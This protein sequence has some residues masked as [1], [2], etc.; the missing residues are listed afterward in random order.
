M[1]IH[2]HR[3]QQWPFYLC[4]SK[5]PPKVFYLVVQYSPER[6]AFSETSSVIRRKWTGN[7]ELDAG[8]ALSKLYDQLNCGIR[9]LISKKVRSID[10]VPEW[11]NRN[12]FGPDSKH[13]LEAINMK[14]VV[15]IKPM[16]Y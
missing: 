12:K 2:I 5:I 9:W 3:D 7:Y 1:I 6:H 11:R 16:L 8:S 10:G 14:T 13:Y 15:R 4:V